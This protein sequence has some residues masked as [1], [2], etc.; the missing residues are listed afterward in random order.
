VEQ[1]DQVTESAAVL[2]VIARESE[3][4][5]DKDY[6]A[7]ARCWVQA[8]YIRMMGWWARGG[9]TVIEGFD[10]LSERIKENLRA[11]PDPNPTASQVRREHINL[12]IG[13]HMAWVT[14]DQYAQDT[15]EPDMDMPGVSH[16]TR[17]LEKHDGEWKLVYVG[18]L[19]EGER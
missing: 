12:R 1:T 3:A 6:D 9:V 7:W 8:S 18:W 10:A 4:F 11:N 5:W 19:L 14:F 16:E 2:R 17:I 15:G 13:H